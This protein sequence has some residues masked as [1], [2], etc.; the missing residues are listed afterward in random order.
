VSVPPLITIKYCDLYEISPYRLPS[1]RV[2]LAQAVAE[3]LIP[4]GVDCV[5]LL[6][7]HVYLLGV[8]LEV[9]NILG[10]VSTLEHRVCG[11]RLLSV[12]MHKV[13]AKAHGEFIVNH[14]PTRRSRRECLLMRSYVCRGLNDWLGRR[15]RDLGDW[16]QTSLHHQRGRVVGVRGSGEGRTIRR[17]CP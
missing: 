4:A 16:L 13:L 9:C 11:L 14:L 5:A 17:G 8:L 3:V 10:S 12:F 6:T 15:P 1:L 2:V 7:L